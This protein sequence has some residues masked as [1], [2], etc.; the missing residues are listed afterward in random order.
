MPKTRKKISEIDKRLINL[1]FI[2]IFLIASGFLWLD[3]LGLINFSQDIFPIIA[4]VPGL[5]YLLPKR[6]EDPFLLAKEEQ[7]KLEYVKQKEWQ[8]K[9]EKEKQL[10]EKEIT[11]NEKT[12][13]IKEQQD[14]LKE[15]EKEI[16]GKYIE[17][18]TYKE[19]VG[20]QAVYLVGMRPEDAVERLSNMNDL[21]IIDILEAIEKKAQEEGQQSIVSYYLSLMEHDKASVIQRKM[22]VVEEDIKETDIKD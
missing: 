10:E 7:K 22:T 14:K 13:W 9:K 20:Q 15:K 17:K 3:Y 2:N 18:E 16:D 8:K 21:L 12:K 11:V 4:K 1:I 6:S 19:K 5:D